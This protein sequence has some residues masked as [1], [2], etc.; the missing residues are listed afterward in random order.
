M[1]SGKI[2]NRILL[3]LSAFLVLFLAAGKSNADTQEVIVSDEDSLIAALNSSAE[4]VR[5]VSDITTFGG[6]TVPSGKEFVFTDGAGGNYRWIISG[7]G[8]T[9]RINSD[10]FFKTYAGNVRIEAGSSVSVRFAASF[11][12]DGLSSGVL[13]SITYSDGKTEDVST[14]GISV[15]NDGNIFVYIASISSKTSP[16]TVTRLN[17]D[18]SDYVAEENNTF[19]REYTINYVFKQTADGS[20]FQDLQ[21]VNNAQNST[22]FTRKTPRF[23]LRQPAKD[24]YQFLGWYIEGA[25]DLVKEITVETGEQAD[26]TYIGIFMKRG[27]QNGGGAG[28]GGFNFSGIV[29]AVES[30][31]KEEK[32]ESVT[33]SS[34]EYTDGVRISTASSGTV[35]VFAD[36]EKDRLDLESVLGSGGEKTTSEGSPLM[37]SGILLAALSVIGIVVLFVYRKK[38]E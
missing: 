4:R 1:K 30:E 22:A 16:K 17:V 36:G 27:G 37:V 10:D 8:I 31:Q 25:Q 26:I 12:I 32:E 6:Y 24:G 35:A 21:G 9:I 34:I 18:G 13:K 38:D 2:M 14:Q 5:F 11:S 7:S 20:T 23:S 19:Y 29:Q 28:I 33:E 15:S 3:V